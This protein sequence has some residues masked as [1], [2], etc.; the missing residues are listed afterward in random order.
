MT[1][2]SVWHLNKHYHWHYIIH[3]VHSNQPKVQSHFHYMK[4]NVVYCHSPLEILMKKLP[5]QV[6]QAKPNLTGQ[7]SGGTCF[8]QF[9]TMI[10]QTQP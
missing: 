10:V 5:I 9:D 8:F 2:P 7:D 4:I 1:D 6:Q 3:Q